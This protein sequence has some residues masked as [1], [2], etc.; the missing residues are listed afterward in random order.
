MPISL[1]ILNAEADQKL[2]LLEKQVGLNAEILT[3][4]IL[5]ILVLNGGDVL[6]SKVDAREMITILDPLV[7]EGLVCV[8][9]YLLSKN[10]KYH[11]VI[12]AKYHD[13]KIKKKF[14]K[15][16]NRNIDEVLKL[17]SRHRTFVEIKINSLKG[18][19]LELITVESLPGIN[20]KCAGRFI[21]SKNQ[22]LAPI[23]KFKNIVYGATISAIIITSIL[24]IIFSRLLARP[25]DNLIRGIEII[26]SGDF[27]YHIEL[28]RK[29]EFGKLSRTINHLVQIVNLEIKELRSR[30]EDLTKL[31]KLK[32]EFLAN[33]SHELRT[34]LYGMIGLAE[35]VIDG[36]AGK[37]NKATKHNLSLIVTS[38]QRL[39]TLVNDII[40]FS[41]LKQE[42]I[43]LEQKDVD[44]YAIVKLVITIS[45]TLIKGKEISLF[46][47]I[48]PEEYFVYVDAN[49]LQQI[50][51][52]IIGNAIKFTERGQIVIGANYEKKSKNMVAITI[53]DTGIGIPKEKHE[54][55]FGLFKQADSSISR[56]YG[57][58]GIGLSITKKL[59][60]LHKGK[61]CIDADYTDGAKFSFTVKKGKKVKEIF[62]L[63]KLDI[64]QE[65]L[66]GNISDND[67]QVSKVKRKKRIINNTG[68]IFIVD[69]EPINCKVM[70]NHLSIE[71]FDVEVFTN[72]YDV[73]KKIEK[74]DIPDLILLDIMLPRVSGYD[75][76]KTIREDYSTS[77][78][79]IIMVTANQV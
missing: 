67:Q 26:G 64:I 32:D 70:S 4:A 8:D 78:L 12:L 31:D 40:D 72:G 54:Y 7:K 30:N 43:I 79:P 57:G 50:L 48:K 53:T 41:L 29:D 15:N 10:K 74:K 5:N 52:N 1:Y 35:S 23:Q 61:I 69:D 63:E 36:V 13:Y 24:A 51:F 27:G 56:S 45:E 71:G 14:L 60:E 22:I 19:Y 55:I 9:T 37:I 16:I 17:N 11:G 20:I 6:K 39:T 68:R 77:E 66:V 62:D 21:F 73:L 44:L 28:N 25:I 47:T 59:V 33:I 58:S 75:V 49:R 2:K 42:A 65:N 18:N 34:P 38:G 76:C 3:K 46:T